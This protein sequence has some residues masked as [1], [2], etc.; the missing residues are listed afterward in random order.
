M[1][2]TLHA[3]PQLRDV[4]REQLRIVTLSLRRE[5]IVACAFLLGIT[6]IM[7]VQAIQG[8]AHTWFDSNDDSFAIAVIA[9]LF[10]FAVWRSEKRF[11]ASFLWTLPVDRQQ[12]AFAKVFAGWVWL[13]TAWLAYTT[14][15]L[16]VAYAA[17]VE[18]GQRLSYVSF[19]ALTAMYL[20]GS[21]IALAFRRPLRWL[22]G[23]AALA[24]LVGNVSQLLEKGPYS[25]DPLLNATA[26][27][28]TDAWSA[29]G[30]LAWAITTLIWLGAG[31]LALWLAVSR[32]RETRRR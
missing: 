16:I 32:H 9:F 18:E 7:S 17:N 5:A 15:F 31:F 14:P 23:A 22:F 30:S 29:G 26:R 11:G 24:L 10:P 8:E 28:V 2:V 1:D 20:I 27:R 12:L 19:I 6:A 25:L 3:V 13:A 21:A 4:V